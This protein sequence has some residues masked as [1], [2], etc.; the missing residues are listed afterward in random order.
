MV[1]VP[2]PIII[3]NV[4]DYVSLD[5]FKTIALTNTDKVD[6]ILDKY[7]LSTSE[8]KVLVGVVLSE[9]DDTYEDAY[10]V[11]NTI[12]NRT[13]SKNWVRIIDSK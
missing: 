8:F 2:K 9:A 11:I 5:T 1:I 10:A 12:Y 3:T 7:H 4:N 13:H 6:I